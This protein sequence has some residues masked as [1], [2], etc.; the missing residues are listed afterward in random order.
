MTVIL[1]TLVSGYR[2]VDDLITNSCGT[3]NCVIS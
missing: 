1:H 3:I 2:N